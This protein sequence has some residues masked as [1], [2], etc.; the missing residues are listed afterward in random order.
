M[1]VGVINTTYT[2]DS[3]SFLCTGNPGTSS[4]ALTHSVETLAGSGGGTWVPAHS[5]PPGPHVAPCV[6]PSLGLPAS[7]D[8]ALILY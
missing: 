4:L 7:R 6:V 5:H 3:N 8:R 1:A 2:K